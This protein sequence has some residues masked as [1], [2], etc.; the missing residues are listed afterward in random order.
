MLAGGALGGFVLSEEHY[1]EEIVDGSALISDNFWIVGQNASVLSGGAVNGI[2]IRR[3]A[4]RVSSGGAANGIVIQEGSMRVSSGGAASATVVESYGHLYVDGGGA[5]ADTIVNGSMTI[6]S[7]G[8]ASILFNPWMKTYKIYAEPGAAVTYLERDAGIYFGRN[9][10]YVGKADVWTSGAIDRDETVLVYRGGTANDTAINQSGLMYL[11][12]GTANDA[13]VNRGGALYVGSGGT[14][15][16][17]VVV[18]YGSMHVSSGGLARDAVVRGGLAF[19]F[20]GGMAR[21]AVVNRG[22]MHIFSGGIAEGGTVVSGGLLIVSN[23]G[24][25]NGVGV[26]ERGSM[27]VFGT[28]RDITIASTGNLYVSNGGA[29]TSA[30]LASSGTVHVLSGGTAG[31]TI[32]SSGGSMYVSNG[33]AHTGRLTIAQGGKMIIAAAASLDFTVAEQTPSGA[34]LINDWSLLTD[35]GAS[36]TI[37]VKADQAAGT[38]ALAANAAKFSKTVTV[39]TAEAVLGTLAVGETLACGDVSYTLNKDNSLLSLTVTAPLPPTPTGTVAE[40]ILTITDPNHDYFGATGGWKVQADQTVEWQDLTT[41]GE[42][43]AYLGLGRFT[44]GKAMP[45]IYVYNAGASYIA[46]YTTDDTG[47]ITGFETAFLGSGALGQVGLA[48]FNA[49]GGSD[50][51][52]RTADGFVGYYANGTFSEIQGL[53]LEW[54]VAALGDVDGN[55][56]ADVV[57]AHE[58]GYV[59]AYLIGT[60]GSISWADLGTLNPS[61]RIAGAGDVN[62]DG[63]DDVIV[64]VGTNYYGAWL[65]GAGA[66]TGFFGIGTFDAEVQDIADY[67]GDGTDD[68]LLRTAT[69]VVGAALITGAD[70]TT[71]AQYGA[72]GAEWSTKGVGIL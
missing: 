51:L 61:T 30:T 15:D 42:G 62:G 41:L 11:M 28:A 69:G 39:R 3:G 50:L 52:L 23:G 55:G 48:D 4:M 22:S 63:T 38:Y 5:A 20:S 13:V 56:C 8:S 45:D 24:M 68:L 21:D 29:A 33:A 67:N 37:T 54:S 72:L 43:F 64:Q 49:D 14:A 27:T 32:I 26:G 40:V 25:V 59:G 7:G 65:C 31:N 36:I 2:I 1:W 44:A 6:A 18:Y 35:R 58:A 66:V 17:A 9:D 34:A 12:G 57:I 46:A 70:A 19:L 47:A 53:G 10:A 16:R 60:N 71:W